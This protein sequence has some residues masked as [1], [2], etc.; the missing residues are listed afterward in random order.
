VRTKARVR[1]LAAKVATVNLI[2][3][4]AEHL[5]LELSRRAQRIKHPSLEDEEKSYLAVG[6]NELS[7]PGLIANRVLP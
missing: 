2:F 5:T 3:S 7:C 1:N 4:R 6:L